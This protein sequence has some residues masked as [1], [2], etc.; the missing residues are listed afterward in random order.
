M[1]V[2]PQ[3]VSSAA[4]TTRV[5][6][7]PPSACISYPHIL[8]AGETLFLPQCLPPTTFLLKCKVL[9]LQAPLTF[10]LRSHAIFMPLTLGMCQLQKRAGGVCHPGFPLASWP[11]C[12]SPSYPPGFA[13]IQSPLQKAHE[14]C[15][16]LFAYVFCPHNSTMQQGLKPARLL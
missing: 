16:E 12:L 7:T 1:G 4:K 5:K 15:A 9:L 3:R 8:V 6:P 13:R 14:V 2:L 10:P 11:S